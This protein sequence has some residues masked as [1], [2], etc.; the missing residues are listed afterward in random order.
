LVESWDGELGDLLARVAGR[1]ARVEP[2]GVPE[3]CRRLSPGS[4]SAFERLPPGA[5]NA[6]RNILVRLRGVD[7][8]Q[9]A[10]E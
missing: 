8:E 4:A 7:R 6:R 9:R 1:F 3:V 10:A 2:R 5:D